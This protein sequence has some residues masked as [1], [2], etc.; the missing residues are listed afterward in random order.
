MIANQYHHLSTKFLPR[1]RGSLPGTIKHEPAGLIMNLNIRKATPQD[2]STINKL[3]HKSVRKLQAP[4]YQESEIETALELING[5]ETLIARNSYFVVENLSVIIGCGGYFLRPPESK[6]AEIR[7][8]FVTPEFS[9]QEI[10]AKIL[11][12]CETDCSNIGI[13][14]LHL[15]STL[16]GEP[17]YKKHGFIEIERFKQCLSNGQFFELVKMAKYTYA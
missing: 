8:F 17:F 5:I 15:T 14:S 2:F 13:E 11:L 10:A 6:E 1:R 7:A 4:Y 12:S 9:R 3:I 16:S